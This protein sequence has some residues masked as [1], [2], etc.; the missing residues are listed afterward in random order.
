[1][2]GAQVQSLGLWFLKVG[3]LAAHPLAIWR[4]KDGDS[5]PRRPSDFVDLDLIKWMVTGAPPPPG[6]WVVG[7]RAPDPTVGGGHVVELPARLV[8]GASPELSLGCVTIGI[9]H[10]E[11]VQVL[12]TGGW[13][14]VHPLLASGYGAQLW[15]AP[16]V[17]PDLDALP[18]SP[19][20]V[21]ILVHGHVELQPD[22]TVDEL[23]PLTE[24]F[25]HFHLVTAGLAKAASG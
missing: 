22:V 1:L 18:Q 12:W 2:T 9:R 16:A 21:S 19:P 5:S 4:G 7:S 14:F 23:P 25:S 24:Q 17:P 20:A 11:R 3:L 10:L 6:L 15:P 13:S 8:G